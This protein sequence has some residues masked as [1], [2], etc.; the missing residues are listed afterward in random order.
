MA[1]KLCG[2]IYDPVFADFI[3]GVGHPEQPKRAHIHMKYCRLRG[4]TDNRT[5]LPAKNEEGTPYSFII[6]NI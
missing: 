5:S 6:L 1:E 4:S 3:T 2:L